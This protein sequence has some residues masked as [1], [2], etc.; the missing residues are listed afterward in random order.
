MKV[1]VLT[2]SYPRDADDVAG[3]FVR[4]AVVALRQAGV[5]VSV[6]SPAGLRHFGIAYGH[7]IVGTLLFAGFLWY[8]FRRLRAT[9]AVGRALA[10]V[11]DIEA[12]H[13]RPLGWG[14]T[15][16]LVG[17]MVANVFYL[18]M[19]FYYFY[20]FAMLVL[21]APVVFRRRLSAR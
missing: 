2:T 12:V 21:A 7:G 15:A 10:A 19:S 9:R 11:G 18:T 20:A 5:D 8:L 17:T 4:D 16:A 1:L 3:T 6:V 14:L 13:V